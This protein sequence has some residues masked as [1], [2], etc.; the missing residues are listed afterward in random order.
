M[1][2]SSLSFLGNRN[3]EVFAGSSLWEI[4]TLRHHY[5]PPVSRYNSSLSLD[6]VCSLIDNTDFPPLLL[7]LDLFCP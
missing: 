6:I 2:K 5:C 3:I 7:L 4:D 1:D